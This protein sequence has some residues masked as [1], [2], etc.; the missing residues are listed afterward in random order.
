MLFEGFLF[1]CVFEGSG[2]VRFIVDL[3]KMLDFLLELM[4]EFF[5]LSFVD[6]IDLGKL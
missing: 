6:E 1:G 2:F 3:L 4:L 5:L